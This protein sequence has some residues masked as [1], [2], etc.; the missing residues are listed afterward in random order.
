MIFHYW[1]L[2]T[3]F[4]Y[5]SF[6]CQS[7]YIYIGFNYIVTASLVPNNCFRFVRPYFFPVIKIYF[8]FP[9]KYLL[10]KSFYLINANL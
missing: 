9:L 6:G 10:L 5:F 1:L 2:T 8:N 7:P 4:T 3:P